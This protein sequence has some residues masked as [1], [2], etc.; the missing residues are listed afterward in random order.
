[1]PNLTYLRASSLVY[2]NRPFRN[3]TSSDSPT[4]VPPQA[5]TNNSIP[6]ISASHTSATA[7]DTQSQ[8]FPYPLT[9]SSTTEPTQMPLGPPYTNTTRSTFSTI[10]TRTLVTPDPVPGND[11]WQGQPF[12]S[13]TLSLQD[14]VMSTSTNVPT[15]SSTSIDA[16]ASSVGETVISTSSTMTSL[17]SSDY[18]STNA[19]TPSFMSY[20][21]YTARPTYPINSSPNEKVAPEKIV[22]TIVGTTCG[23][24]TFFLAVFAIGAWW[25][26]RRGVR[27]GQEEMLGMGG[28]TDRRALKKGPW[29]SGALKESSSKGERMNE[30]LA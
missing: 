1:M 21:T 20:H 16:S 9:L 2:T 8:P 30:G 14:T 25:L 13:E 10:T 26:H 12:T 18:S 11:P 23:V 17:P 19:Y 28:E 4:Q 5:S 24:V 6:G 3:V 27:K 15:T 29:M 7:P 22:S